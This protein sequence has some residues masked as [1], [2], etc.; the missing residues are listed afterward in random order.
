ML[1][2][3]VG[4]GRVHEGRRRRPGSWPRRWSASATPTA[5]APPPCSPTWTRRSVAPAATPSRW[6]RSIE[7]L[8][9]RGPAD[10]VEITLALAREMLALAGHRRRRPD[11][12]LAS[13]RRRAGVEGDGDGPGRRPRAPACRRRRTTQVV[14]APAAGYV[15]R[16]DALGVGVCAWRLGAGRARKEDPVSAVGR[17]GVPGQAGRRA[18][19]RASPCWSCTS[20]TRAASPGALEALDGAIDDRPGA[21]AAPPLVIEVIR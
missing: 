2:V 11:E 15:T 3:K 14:R 20:T 5:C 8:Q 6:P 7:T 9:G 1:D 12:A 18:W 13:R 4:V 19:R 17:R 10:L 21:A 16:L